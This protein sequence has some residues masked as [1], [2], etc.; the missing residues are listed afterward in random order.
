MNPIARDMLPGL[1]AGAMGTVMINIVAYADMAIMAIR[2]RA[3]SYM[4]QQIAANMGR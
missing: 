1:G 3:P 2:W 4:P